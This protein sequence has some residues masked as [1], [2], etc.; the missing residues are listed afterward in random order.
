MTK[1]EIIVKYYYK[2]LTFNMKIEKEIEKVALNGKNIE[3]KD[4]KD[5]KVEIKYK[6]IKDSNL[7]VFY[8]IKVTNT[9]K[10]PGK[11]VIEEILP[12]GFEFVIEE[13]NALFEK[14]DNKYIL[15][16]EEIKP[17]E[18]KEY[19]VTLRWKQEEENK[20]EKQNTAKIGK[21][22]NTANCEE[23]TLEDNE[24]KATIEIKLNK[25][26]KDVITDIFD[27]NKEEEKQDNNKDEEIE[28][29]KAGQSRIIYISIVILVVGTVFIIQY[30]KKKRSKNKRR[31]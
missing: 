3:I 17:E 28:M 5:V 20:G 8:K 22:T 29:P 13:S 19:K 4:N 26:I 24:A 15:Q 18:T 11:V 7:E 12:E 1:E 10:L 6:D 27:N 9:E 16:T 25:T 14:E 21:T 30:N 31:K 2:K 23:T